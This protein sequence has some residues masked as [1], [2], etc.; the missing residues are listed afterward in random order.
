MDESLSEMITALRGPTLNIIVEGSSDCWGPVRLLRDPQIAETPILLRAPE[1]AGTP[2]VDRAPQIVGGSS[3]CW[4]PLRLL[5]APRIAGA[6]QIALGPSD[7]WGPSDCRDRG[8]FRLL[9]ALQIAGGFSD[10]WGPSDWWGSSN[11]L[12]PSDCW[13]SFRLLRAPQIAGGP[14]D[15]WGPLGLKGALR[16]LGALVHCTTCTTHCYA[17][18]LH[19]WKPVQ[20][21]TDI[22]VNVRIQSTRWA[23]AF[24]IL[25]IHSVCTAVMPQIEHSC[26]SQPLWWQM[27]ESEFVLH[28]HWGIGVLSVSVAA[29]RST[30]VFFFK[31]EHPSSAPR[32]W[33]HPGR[34]S[35]FVSKSIPGKCCNSAC[36]SIFAS[37]IWLPFQITFYL[38]GSY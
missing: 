4:E 13:G 27:S 28:C 32:W 8:P 23:A 36:L 10:C 33:Q 17:T 9:R 22:G 19:C 18:E 3:D 26:N 30:N 5:G 37:C 12:G 24:K 21:V 7:W 6:L 34:W 15:C 29:D 16:W 1:I 35:L 11:W 38:Y 2:Q 31:H 20:T 14:S 25:W